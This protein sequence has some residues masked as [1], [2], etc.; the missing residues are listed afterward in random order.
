MSEELQHLMERIQREAVDTGEQKAAEL[1]AQAKEQAAALLR[2]A[3][4]KAQAMVQRAEQE[5]LQ[6]TQRSQQTLKQAARD[7]LISVGQGVETILTKFAVETV[8]QAMTP[9]VLKD[10]LVKLAGSLATAEGAKAQLLLS[11]QD[12]ARLMALLQEKL[13]DQM[14]KGLMITGDERVIKGF[15]VSLEGGRVK[16]QFTPES[17]AESLSAFLRPALADIVYQAAREAGGARA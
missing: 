17:I 3:E 5:S 13:R 10:L 16:H 6:Y 12:Q 14:Q 8:G 11:P 15:Q 2:D 9:D 1:V 7:V 4:Q